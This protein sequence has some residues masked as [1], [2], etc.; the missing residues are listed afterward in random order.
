[1]K[2]ELQR[3]LKKYDG[4]IKASNLS[5]FLL[6][7][8]TFSGQVVRSHS[9]LSNS[10][11]HVSSATKELDDLMASLSD[12]KVSLFFFHLKLITLGLVSNFN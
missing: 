8:T 2:N 5:N 6:F 4:N 10:S 9:S 1:V 11:Q 12:F 7:P 3:I